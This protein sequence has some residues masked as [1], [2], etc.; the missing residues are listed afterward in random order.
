M[1]L[2][3]PN[4]PSNGQTF[5]AGAITYT[6]D[7]VKWVAGVSAGA[8]GATGT[9]G[10][11]GNIGAQGATGATGLAGG[12]SF[13]VTNSGASAY[14]I[15]GGTNPTLNLI[16]GFTYYF[17]VSASGHPFW[18][19]TSSV[20]GTGSAYTSGVTNNGVDTGLITFAVPFDAPSTLYYI[21][22]FHGSMAGTIAISDL[23]PTGATG[24]TGTQGIQGIQGV[25]GATGIQG[26]VGA[27]GATGIQGNVGATGA[28]GIQGNVGPI[29][30]TGIQ[31]NVGAT[32]P[33]GPAGNLTSVSSNIVPSANITYDLGT[34][35]LRWRDLYLSG[36]SLYLGGAVISANANV[37]VL[38]AGSLIGNTVIG[39]GSGGASIVTSNTAPVAP[40][41]G[42]LWF[43]TDTGQLLVYYSTGWAGIAAGDGATGATGPTGS[44]GNVGATGAF[45]GTLSSTMTITNTTVSTS[46][47][48]GALT[49]AGGVGIQGN[50]FA[51]AVYTNSIFYAN[52]VAYVTGGGGGGGGGGVILNLDGGTPDSIYGGITA[53]DG[54]APT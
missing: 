35:S 47:L 37:V 53:I 29:G 36:S 33:A 32:G 27:S 2:N 48:T 25:Q 19:K 22:Q 3:F 11:Q 6:Y 14:T 38:P 7:G 5:I 13:A 30:A 10:I 28:T 46:T 15:N 50:V 17:N 9:Q 39:T 45:S 16:R 12:A 18:I 23:G 24:A 40:V 51:G 49:V 31:G 54:G 8:T 44:Q 43:D 26:N 20:T 34:S 4:S 42:A 1:A 21:C 52:G 41:N